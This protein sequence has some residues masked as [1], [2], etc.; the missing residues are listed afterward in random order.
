MLADIQTLNDLE[1]FESRSSNNGEKSRTVFDLVDK[2]ITDKGSDILFQMLQPKE[3]GLDT[4]IKR[5]EAVKYIISHIGKWKRFQALFKDGSVGESDRYL[6]SNLIADGK[7]GVL[8]NAVFQLKEKEEYFFILKGVENTRLVIQKAVEFHQ[9]VRTADLPPVLREALSG[10]DNLQSD[11]DL[12]RASLKN[13]PNVMKTDHLFRTLRRR[14]LESVFNSIYQ[15][16]ALLSMAVATQDLGF[17]FPVF[18]DKPKS[19]LSFKGLYH[20]FINKPVRNDYNLAEKNFVFI[21]GPNMA[22]KTT[23]M[24][25]AGLCVYLAHAGMSVPA[26]SMKL[27]VFD[28]LISSI[29]TEDNIHLGYSY[30][31]SEVKR[32]KTMAEFINENSRSV[33]I[34]DEM[35]KGTNVKDA[36]DATK[37]IVGK[38]VNY[39]NCVFFLSSHITELG[40]P[41]AKMKAVD[42]RNFTAKQ[43]V[44]GV[45][46]DYRIRRG[47]SDQRLGLYIL[48]KEDIFGILDRKSA[49]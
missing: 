19:G 20:P 45:S 39:R 6:S 41:L 32:V 18:T 7:A 11:N 30:F 47:L 28:G 44:S 14:T 31:Y 25:A 42:F 10:L 5:Q 34:M 3:C 26:E 17:T 48:E 40:K 35:F 29:N 37:T 9:A 15:L 46:Y 13:D 43:S 4:I 23:F 38:L 33:V 16:D 21:T 49:K 1:L 12:R 36:H 22:G 27:S 2:T 24:K 8:K